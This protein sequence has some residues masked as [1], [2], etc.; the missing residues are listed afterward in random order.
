[1]D[2]ELRP[3]QNDAGVLDLHYSQV[4]RLKDDDDD[5]IKDDVGFEDLKWK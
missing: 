3:F 1:M 5:G 4:E 2:W